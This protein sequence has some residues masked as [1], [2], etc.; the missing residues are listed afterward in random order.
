MPIEDAKV[1]IHRYGMLSG[2]S[3]KEDRDFDLTT[4]TDGTASFLC[5]QCFC[6]GT[7]SLFRETFWIGLPE[8]YYKPSAAGYVA[9]KWNDLVQFDNQRRVQRGDEVAT[10]DV[11]IDLEKAGQQGRIPGQP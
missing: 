3:G 11:V 6:S 5:K 4:G 1:S 8:W 10:L 2:K 7:K 9:R